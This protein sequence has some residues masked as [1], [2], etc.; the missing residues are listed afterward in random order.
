MRGAVYPRRRVVWTWK[1][2]FSMQLSRELF[3]HIVAEL[4]SAMVGGHNKRLKP[5]VGLRN[6]VA[7]TLLKDHKPQAAASVVVRDLSPDGIGF[8]LHRKLPANALFSIRLPAY[9]AADLVAVYCVKHCDMIFDDL[10]RIGGLLVSINNPDEESKPSAGAGSG[11]VTAAKPAKSPPKAP[12]AAAAAAADPATAPAATTPRAAR[13]PNHS[14][15][16]A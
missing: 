14:A 11:A 4:R 12:P 6:H 3:Q 10:F 5:R 9:D 8:L 16:A 15:H 13:S 2:S 1:W 7:M